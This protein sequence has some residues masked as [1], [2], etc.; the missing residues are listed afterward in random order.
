MHRDYT[1]ISKAYAEDVI[2]DGIPACRQIKQACQR[3]LNDL[4]SDTWAYDA[5]KAHKA[6]AFIELLPHVKGELARKRQTLILEPW[7][8]FIICN[9]FG[10]VDADGLRK[11]REAFILVP[12]KNGKS[13]LASGIALYM[14]FMDGEMGAEVWIGAN[15]MDQAD[16]VFVPAKKMAEQPMFVAAF[17][18]EVMAQ[19]VTQAST[20]NFVRPMIGKPRDG[21]NPHCGILDESHEAAD[22]T[23]YDAMQTGMGSRTQPL[24]VTITT[25]GVNLAGPCF[26]QQ[27]YAESV[28][29]G[30]ADNP[31]LFAMIFTIDQGDSWQDF[32]CWKKANPNLGI[33]VSE[34]YLKDQHTVALQRPEKASMAQTKH[35]NKW[36]SSREAWLNMADWSNSADASLALEDFH[37]CTATLGLDLATKTD[38][39]ALVARVTTPEGKVALFPYLF[40]PEGALTRSKSAESYRAWSDRGDLILTD[41]EATDFGVIEDKVRE[42]CS[43]LE[44]QQIGCDQWQAQ[45][46]MQNLMADGLPVIQCGANTKTFAPAMLEFEALLVDGHLIHPD[47]HAFNWMAGNVVAKA[48]AR[49][50]LYP[51]KPDGQ[52][53]LKIDGIVAALMAEA[54]A[55]TLVEAVSDPFIDVW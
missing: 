22:A 48:D 21:T 45:Q 26:L 43:R 14:A 37:G 40:L 3:F 7:Q 33:S 34:T 2:G 1:A 12:R 31:R 6:C 9:L 27:R 23:A 18:V 30:D 46:M 17:G 19:S 13:T 47:N 32:E 52:N 15:S 54:V 11:Y 8:V 39:A 49:G 35:L 10:F 28:L 5:A 24:L 38:V 44:V 53:H 51:R 41:G 50:N 4:E 25:A 16:A 36:V 55:Q 20:G 42:L 29:A